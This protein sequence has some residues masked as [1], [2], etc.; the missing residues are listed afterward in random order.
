MISLHWHV[1][2]KRKDIGTA[3]GLLV[4]GDCLHLVINLPN[5]QNIAS[6]YQEIG[7]VWST[8]L[9]PLSFTKWLFYWKFKYSMFQCFSEISDS[10]NCCSNG[11]SVY[12]CYEK[13]K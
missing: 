10:G 6:E 13:K 3:T 8:S 1:H 12:K 5:L 9:P 7:A 11:T 2:A 4:M